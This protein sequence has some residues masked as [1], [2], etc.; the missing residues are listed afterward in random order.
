LLTECQVNAINDIFSD[1]QANKKVFR[2]IQGDVGC[3]K[4]VVFIAAMLQVHQAKK[5]SV[6]LSATSLLAEQHYMTLQKYLKVFNIEIFLIHSKLKYRDKTAIYN[7]ISVGIPCIIVTTTALLSANLLYNNL[8]LV[9]IDEQHKF[10]V[11]QI[12][13][14]TSKV[15]ALRVHSLHYI[16]LSATPI[17]RTL[18]MANYSHLSTST[19]KTKP[20]CR[21][22]TKTFVIS[23]NKRELVIK[24]LK[25]FLRS[26][27]RAYWV[28][29]RKID[30]GNYDSVVE[31]M[32]ELNDKLPNVKIG[33]VHGSMS[34]ENKQNS[35]S[36]FITGEIQLLVTTT[37]IEVGIDICDAEM[38]IIE[39]AERL[40][41][42]QLHQLRGR[43]GRGNTVGY[44]ILIYNETSNNSFKHRLF[45]FKNCFDGSQIAEID[46]Q[47]RGGGNILGEE[48]S[49]YGRWKVAKWSDIPKLLPIAIKIANE[50]DKIDPN[51]RKMFINRWCS[52]SNND[53]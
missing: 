35:F 17:P 38:I 1:W 28:C 48:Q 44:C 30:T 34:D 9:V 16:M 32:N 29:S 24:S 7:K 12:N 3:G 31:I 18:L 42:A 53:N 51:L 13:I 33:M 50:I 49:G 39:N 5:Q 23:N 10:G 46:L 41:L 37:V 21:K 6:L 27:K 40:G 45:S 26:G 43:V 36:R 2:L 20:T 19:I 11:E 22:E 8:A 25:G 47:N 4:T 14:L 52:N 15:E